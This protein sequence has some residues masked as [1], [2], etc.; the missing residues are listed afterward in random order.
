MC[1]SNV[2]LAGADDETLVMESVGWIEF[3]DGRIRLRD[4]LGQERVLDARVKY[5]DL[6]QHRIVL[7]PVGATAE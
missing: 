7:E 2:F 1:E 5:A 4:M 3:E 6:V